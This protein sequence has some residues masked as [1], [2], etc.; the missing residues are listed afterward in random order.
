MSDYQRMEWQAF[1]T[2]APHLE[3]VK[4]A[5]AGEAAPVPTGD[6]RTPEQRIAFLEKAMLSLSREFK[7]VVTD[8][9]GY[10]TRIANLELRRPNTS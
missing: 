6:E 8:I 3:I 4:E 10:G 9:G 7:A 5:P 2:K 1:P